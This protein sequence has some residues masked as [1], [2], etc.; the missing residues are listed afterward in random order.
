MSNL[1]IGLKHNAISETWFEDIGEGEYETGITWFIPSGPQ[2]KDY[3][4]YIIEGLFR[5]KKTNPGY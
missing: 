1:V 4:S 5:R 2:R 3:M